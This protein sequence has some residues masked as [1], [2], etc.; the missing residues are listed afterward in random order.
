MRNNLRLTLLSLSVSLA[1]AAC[2][3]GGGGSPTATSPSS[4]T[5]NPGGTSG[6]TSGGN[7]GGTQ[8]G[9]GGGTPTSNAPFPTTN[10]PMTM[11]CFDTP[12]AGTSEQCSGGDI[13]IPADKGNGVVVTNSGVQV[14]GISTSDLAAN[15]ANK[16]KAT[17]LKL[18]TTLG[19]LAELRV[20]K[21][22]T[23]FAVSKPVLLLS[24]LGIKWDGV[25]ERPPI[26]EAFLSTQGRTDLAGTNRT[27]S[28]TGLPAASTFDFN[29]TTHTGTQSRYA[30][31]SYFPRTGNPS[32]CPTNVTCP[33]AETTAGSFSF[34][35]GNWQ[36]PTSGTDPDIASAGRLHEDGDVHAPDVPFPGS[37]GYRSLFNTSYH[38]ANMTKW[39]SQDTAEIAEWAGTN[40]EH[41]LNRRGIVAFGEVVDPAKMPTTG[42]ATYA[43]WLRGWYAPNASTEPTSFMAEVTLTVDFAARTVKLTTANAKPDDGATITIPLVLSDATATAATV[44]IGAAS[45]N[46]ANYLTGALTSGSLKGGIGGRFFGPKDLTGALPPEMGASLSMTD[47]STGASL[48]GGFIAIKRTP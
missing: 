5:G 32:R 31:N 1:L 20:F 26:I 24:N 35:G 30:N 38:Y 46:V 6:G 4:Q 43:G 9:S 8:P 14:Y 45:T 16:D 34:A 25:T 28:I 48:I 17:G 18:P 33:P 36:A 42:S 21:N 10:A 27:L 12:D 29:D 41:N 39:V 44:A 22:T 37:K 19:G 2:G 15:N 13:A 47:A 3:G 11:A 23:S 7:T 40:N